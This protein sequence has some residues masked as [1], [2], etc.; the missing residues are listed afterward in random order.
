MHENV[1]MQSGVNMKP[2]QHHKPGK[3]VFARENIDEVLSEKIADH[4]RETRG[5]AENPP[6]SKYDEPSGI[7][8]EKGIDKEKWKPLLGITA[9]VLAVM[10]VLGAVKFISRLIRDR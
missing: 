1:F 8:T 6:Q 9:A 2:S 10:C 3:P 4:S 7:N 5:P